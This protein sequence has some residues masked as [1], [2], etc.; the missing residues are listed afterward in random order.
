MKM[1]VFLHHNFCANQNGDTRLS[2]NPKK[3]ALFVPV[4]ILSIVEE[5][6]GRQ[7][8]SEILRLPLRYAQGSLRMTNM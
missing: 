1:I 2:N 4:V 8:F 5:S 7:S 3:G 6:D